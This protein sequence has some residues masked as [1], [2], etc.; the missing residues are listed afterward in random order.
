MIPW[1]TVPISNV[2][3]FSSL[4]AAVQAGNDEVTKFEK[5]SMQ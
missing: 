4:I 3:L 1:T 2:E 5:K